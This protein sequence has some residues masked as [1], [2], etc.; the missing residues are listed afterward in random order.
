MKRN[1]VDWLLSAAII[2]LVLAM[3]T[4]CVLYTRAGMQFDRDCKAAGGVPHYSEIDWICV[5][6]SEVIE[7]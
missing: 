4:A 3:L 5:R 1:W 6:R 7:L 2:G